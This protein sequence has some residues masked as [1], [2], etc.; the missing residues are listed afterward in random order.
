LVIGCTEDGGTIFVELKTD[1]V[2]GAEFAAVQTLLEGSH[3]PI[4]VPALLGDDFF[5]GRR[6]AELGGVPPG[7]HVVV[8][9]LV[10]ADRGPITERRFRLDVS[11]STGLTALLTRSCRSVRCT[12]SETCVAGSC[13]PDDCVHPGD[14]SCPA[15][16]CTSV[17]ACPSPSTCAEAR[18]DQGA[19]LYASLGTC[20][21]GAYCS[22][23]DGCLPV[24]GE[25][26][27]GGVGSLWPLTSFSAVP[28][29]AGA[30]GAVE[31]T[32]T[33]PTELG[34]AVRLEVRRAPGNDAPPNCDTGQTV[35]TLSDFAAASGT[36]I[37]VVDDPWNRL[38]GY[39]A[40]FFDAAGAS[41]TNAAMTATAVAFHNPGPGCRHPPCQSVDSTAAA[42]G[43]PVRVLSALSPT[44]SSSGD[45]RL[46]DF[47]GDG[48][49]DVVLATNAVN[50]AHL[51]N[52]D[53]TFGI[54]VRLGAD[55]SE[56][57]ALT[58]GDFDNDGNIDVVF[59]NRDA[60]SLIHL[61][62]GDGTFDAGTPV[63]PESFSA[64][65]DIEAADLNEDTFLDL[66][67]TSYSDFDRVYLGDGA[68]R[69]TFHALLKP[70]RNESCVNCLALHD[71][72]GDGHVDIVI[73]YNAG[74]TRMDVFLGTGS[75]SFA[76]P[77]PIPFD[78]R[79]TPISVRLADVDGDGLLDLVAGRS[80]GGGI[81]AG[82]GDGA[83]NFTV[84]TEV[85]SRSNSRAYGLVVA[86]YDAD[87]A[88]DILFSQDD[89]GVVGFLAGNGDGTFETQI[90][91][92]SGS[93]HTT[94]SMETGDLNGDGK[95]DFV[96]GHATGNSL[97]FLGR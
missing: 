2:A 37:D 12:G 66:V 49:L 8:V 88:A 75:A 40:C 17:S 91:L 50:A 20:G 19:C 16:Q 73:G 76:P 79:L 63:Y 14:A 94:T 82:L 80:Q 70:E 92:D 74:D 89:G 27:D 3:S 61:G 95:L 24:L 86:D 23:E 22:P 38:H 29:S 46:A 30:E 42:L 11:G 52:G 32:Y 31:I 21:A 97:V 62:N 43:P 44:G 71:L 84:L 51:G 90:D 96:A 64:V 9:T 81:Y 4:E 78:L 55:A 68:G 25:T 47:D 6:V 7:R 1:L 26:P 72:N 59:A 34:D 87:G 83:G 28:A 41:L 77:I 85:P 48:D 54:A 36:A 53:G 33:L 13:V 60:P 39:R 5:D 45:V 67:I 57:F 56:S 93:T 35:V 65:F 18:C 10:A 58:T 15:P 69:F